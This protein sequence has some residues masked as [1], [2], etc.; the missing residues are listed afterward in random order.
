MDYNIY[1][2]S[3]EG[4]G[5]QN[6]TT[7]WDNRESP[8]MPWKPNGVGEV[9]SAIANPDSLVSRGVGALVKAVPYVAAAIVVV[10][11]AQSVY[12]DIVLPHETMVTGD[13]RASVAY[14][15]FQN[16]LHRIF[17]PFSHQVQTQKARL[18]MKIEDAKRA[19][20][21]LLVGDSELNAYTGV[22]V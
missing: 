1:I 16:E 7:P 4:G 18:E 21:R 3:V 13:Y 6:P 19:Q 14:A 22:G 12:S 2:R 15:N 11:A 17:S 8:T 10:K 5:Y 9:A 20:N